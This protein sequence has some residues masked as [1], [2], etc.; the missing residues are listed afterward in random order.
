M[1]RENF[2]GAISA[3]AAGILTGGFYEVR[4]MNYEVQSD[5]K[6]GPSFSS[7]SC[8]ELVGPPLSAWVLV[9]PRAFEN[10]GRCGAGPKSDRA[11]DSR[12]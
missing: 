1:T 11:G 9:R 12:E 4:S 5:P 2:V 10:A 7:L 6:D 3:G 8:V